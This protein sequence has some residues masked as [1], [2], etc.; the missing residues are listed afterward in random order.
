MAFKVS[1]HVL[2]PEHTKLTKEEKKMLLSRYHVTTRELPKILK[3]DPAISHLNVEPGDVIRVIRKSMTA[4][5]A[6]YYRVVI[7]G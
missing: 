2:V 6:T 4:G 7:R 5:R 3:S 1:E